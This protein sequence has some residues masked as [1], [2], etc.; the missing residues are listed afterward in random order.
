MNDRQN[1]IVCIFDVR[2]PRITALQIH[3]W[4]YEN[5]RLPEKDVRMIQID[6]PGRRVFIKL[7]TSEQAQLILQITKGQLEFRHDNGELSK[8]QL[9]DLAGMGIR[10]IRIANLPPEVPDRIIRETLSTYGE[11]TEISEETWSKAYK[12]PVPN[13]IRIAVTRLK[14]HIPSHM[15]MAGNRVL[16]SYESQP[17]TCYGCNEIGHQYH[18]CPK[19]R[20]INT[21]NIHSQASWAEVVT[22]RTTQPQ[23]EST[24]NMETTIQILHMS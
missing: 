6:G 4:I 10:R 19:R 12:Y 8:V 15:T 7:N 24:Q 13:G 18:E 3:E 14:K 21:Q 23:T 2:S 22:Q 5:L 20:K 9:K 1:T 16:I 11:V 17:T